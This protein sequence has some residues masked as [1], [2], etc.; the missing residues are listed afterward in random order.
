MPKLYNQTNMPLRNKLLDLFNRA[1]ES[2]NEALANFVEQKLMILDSL[3]QAPNVYNEGLGGGITQGYT[4]KGSRE[5]D[6]I[7]FTAGGTY[8]KIPTYGENP[9]KQGRMP[10]YEG[11]LAGMTEE[12]I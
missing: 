6:S 10:I 5:A 3:P 12:K 8:T 9:M 11:G 4:D 2:G 7:P 1:R